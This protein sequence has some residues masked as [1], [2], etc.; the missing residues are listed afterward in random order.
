MWEVGDSLVVARLSVLKVRVLCP[1]PRVGTRATELRAV[2]KNQ[3]LSALRG[4]RHEKS[5]WLEFW[6]NENESMCPDVP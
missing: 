4:R 1:E 3:S 2:S 5:L 6:P